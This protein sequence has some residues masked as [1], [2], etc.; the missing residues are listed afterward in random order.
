MRVAFALQQIV[1][2]VVDTLRLAMSG[3]SVDTPTL[4][5]VGR[6]LGKLTAW[7]ST[8]FDVG[9]LEQEVFSSLLSPERLN[10]LFKFTPLF[11]RFLQGTTERTVLELALKTVLQTC[12]LFGGNSTLGQRLLGIEFEASNK[13]QRMTF[14]FLEYLL[15]TILCYKGPMVNSLGYWRMLN[16]VVKCADLICWCQFLVTGKYKTFAEYASSLH[17]K[18]HP[19]GAY[20]LEFEF[21]ERQLFVNTLEQFAGGALKTKRF[22]Q[23]LFKKYVLSRQDADTSLKGTKQCIKCSNED[24]VLLKGNPCGHCICHWC[25]F[26]GGGV[27]CCSTVRHLARIK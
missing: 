27:S 1:L 9:L 8:Q 20:S 3:Y 12:L 5:R 15:P 24:G 16:S 26:E 10:C 13:I 25:C 18:K 21:V 14:V 4:L 19:I 2:M 7:R 23:L 6:S 17:V 22:F 11:A